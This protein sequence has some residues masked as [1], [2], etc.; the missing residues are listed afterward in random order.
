[1]SLHLSKPQTRETGSLTVFVVF[2]A[3]ALFAL[4]GLVVDSGRAIS[5]RSAAMNQAEQAARTG[6]GQLS[7]QGL[8]SGQVEI[9]PLAAVEAAEAY[10][11]SVG[12]TGTATVSGNVVTV[13]VQETEPTVILQIVGID[14]IKISVEA[15]AMDV[16]GITRQD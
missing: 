9:D 4:V 11:S 8:R 6:A 14:R 16:R 13:R 15:S 12:D 2:L 1:V 10:L 7:I 5:A 3:L